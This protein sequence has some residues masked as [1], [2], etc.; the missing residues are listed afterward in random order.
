M[1]AP[2]R[3]N[4]LDLCPLQADEWGDEVETVG[5]TL[6]LPESSQEVGTSAPAS[7]VAP[8]SAGL[9]ALAPHQPPHLLYPTPAPSAPRCSASSSTPPTRS[10]GSA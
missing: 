1:T 3:L 8:P 4:T 5:N 10:S 7:Q 9:P 2:P 6:A